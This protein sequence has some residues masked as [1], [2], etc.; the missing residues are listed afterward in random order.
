[1]KPAKL[2]AGVEDME[3]ALQDKC[4]QIKESRAMITQLLSQSTVA[5]TDFGTAMESNAKNAETQ[6]ILEN[7]NF[8]QQCDTA[9]K[10]VIKEVEK[11]V[12]Q[13]VKE[14]IE[15]EKIIEKPI[16]TEKVHVVEKIITVEVEKIQVVEKI[17]E[18]PIEIVKIVEVEKIKEVPVEII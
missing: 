8:G 2:A 14:L 11:I 18:K 10:E 3:Q 1:M 5:T 17:V 6:I 9:P 4:H 7:T 12:V 13:T 15:I 16:I